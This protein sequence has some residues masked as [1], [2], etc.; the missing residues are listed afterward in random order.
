MSANFYDVS[1]K[2]LLEFGIQVGKRG[3]FHFCSDLTFQ[4]V[5]LALRIFESVHQRLHK[6]GFEILREILFGEKLVLRLRPIDR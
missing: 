3:R 6:L 1:A 2:L 4:I 5:Q